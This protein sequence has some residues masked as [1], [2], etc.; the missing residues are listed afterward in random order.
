MKFIAD[1]HI[2]SR[3]SRA[4]SKDMTLENIEQWAQLKGISVIG[5]GDFTHPQWF[6]DIQEKLSL[7]EGGLFKLR[8]PSSNYVPSSCRRQ[9]LFILSAEISSI[10]SKN[11]RLRKVHNLI[12]VPDL[13]VA[14][15]INSQLSRIGNLAADGRPI[16]GLDSKDLLEICLEASPEVI[17]IPAH[18]WTPHFSIF[19]SNSGF[20][21]MEE[22]FEELSPHIKAIETGLSSDP[23]MNWR[24]K[25]LDKVTL[26]SN[27]DAHSPAKIGRE[28]NIIEGNLTYAHIKKAI[29]KKDGFKG[30]I[31]FFPEEGKY[32]FDGHRLCQALLSP[33]ETKKLH[34]LCPR[35]GKKVTVGVMH[36]VEELADRPEGFKLPGAPPYYSLVPLVEIIA[37]VRGTGTGTKAVTEEYNLLLEKLGD[38]LKI[39]LDVP[40]SQI[41][42]TSSPILA[43]G[44]RRVREGKIKISPGYDGEYGKIEVISPEERD[45]FSQQL[46]LF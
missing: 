22:C 27:S 45:K 18:A 13:E 9:V 38:E 30:T 36:R 35:C 12:L 42:K 21:S 40:I 33:G 17:F 8:S 24:V 15:K 6:K 43:E 23:P 19:G 1:L 28:A 37:Q 44:I 39:L 3:F 20:D 34:E 31:E 26:V 2:H 4:T 46:S 16:L 25:A 10:Y 32:H 11:N 7:I 5:T 41:K 29:E 14:S